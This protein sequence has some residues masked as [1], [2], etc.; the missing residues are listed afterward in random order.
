M[1]ECLSKT[2]KKKTILVNNE[3]DVGTGLLSVQGLFLVNLNITALL[4]YR[5]VFFSSFSTRYLIL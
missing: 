3:K 1:Y 2:R 5:A 4:R